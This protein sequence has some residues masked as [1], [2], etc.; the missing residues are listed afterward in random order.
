MSGNQMI[1]NR[2]V[3]KDG[4][5]TLLLLWLTKISIIKNNG[6]DRNNK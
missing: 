6:I 3:R 1:N 4:N 5:G 2:L